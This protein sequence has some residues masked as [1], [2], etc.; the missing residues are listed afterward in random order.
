MRFLTF[1]YSWG[2][3]FLHL[4]LHLCNTIFNS[5]Q[6]SFGIRAIVCEELGPAL[7]ETMVGDLAFGFGGPKNQFATVSWD[8][9]SQI[10]Q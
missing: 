7:S 1:F 9:S 3:R 6:L 4:C 2:Q 8:F 5:L 10:S